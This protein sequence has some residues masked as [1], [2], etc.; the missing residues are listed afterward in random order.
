MES[1][2]NPQAICCPIAACPARGQFGKGNLNIHDQKKKRYRCNVCGHAF[3]QT[4]GTPFYRLHHQREL[5]TTVIKL[6]AKGC[7]REAIVFA[8]GLDER[9][10]ADWEA[11]GDSS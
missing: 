7:P 5:F 9:T 10:V 8:S 11:R 1:R 2:L 3:S 6:L 4:K